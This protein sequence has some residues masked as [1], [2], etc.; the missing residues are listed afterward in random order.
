MSPHGSETD[1]FVCGEKELELSVA[2]DTVM[3]T[4]DF[5]GSMTQWWDHDANPVTPESTRWN[6][7]HGVVET[8]LEDHQDQ[9]EFGLVLFPS[10]GNECS[11]LS[12]PVVPPALDNKDAILTAMPEADSPYV[13]GGTPATLGLAAAINGVLAAGGEG[14]GAVALIT[15]GLPSCED[16]I[17]SLVAL[18]AEGYLNFDVRTFVI[19]VGL[20]PQSH[21][22]MDSVAEAG[23][24]V[25]FYNSADEAELASIAESVIGQ[26]ASCRV[27]LD[28]IPDLPDQLR[29]FFDG[30]E[31]PRVDDCVQ[32]TGWAYTS[33]DYDEIRLCGGWCD[34]LDP[35]STELT[36]D[37]ACPSLPPA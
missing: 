2:I 18:A 31:I 26:A 12:S 27:E 3:L 34:A 1:E 33:A 19:G 5:S 29:V 4:L 7:L 17:E 25:N 35:G 37:Y 32:E 28:P 21:A 10:G 13:V 6:A 8:I 9:V 22:Q 23:G 20:L 36:A 16:D 15:D 24:T 11:V 30:Q 14:D